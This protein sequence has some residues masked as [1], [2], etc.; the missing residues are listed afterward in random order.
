MKIARF[1]H[2]GS[3]HLGI[4]DSDNATV[5]PFDPMGLVPDPMIAAIEQ[6]LGGTLPR[7]DADPIG[8]EAVTLLHPI[9]RPSKNVICVGKNYREHAEEFSRS[10]FDSSVGRANTLFT[11]K[12]MSLT[13]E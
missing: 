9:A 7:L 3:Q 6:C 12:C 1:R 2:A 8:L 5:T 11:K 10:G 13:Q 4:V